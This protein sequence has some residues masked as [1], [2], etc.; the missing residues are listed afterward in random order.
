MQAKIVVALHCKEVKERISGILTS[1]EAELCYAETS[2]ECLQLVAESTPALLILGEHLKDVSA[3][4]LASI[5]RSDQTKL[6]LPMLLLLDEQQDWEN[7]QYAYQESGILD[8][9]SVPIQEGLLRAKTRVYLQ[10][11]TGRRKQQE[12]IEY[13]ERSNRELRAFAH[14]AAHDLKAPL[15][16]I[17]HFSHILAED[18]LSEEER[19]RFLNRVA[20]S[21]THMD[22]MLSQILEYATVGLHDS[23]R[24]LLDLDECLDEV[25]IRLERQIVDSRA[26]IS[27][28]PL[29]RLMGYKSLLLRLLQNLL[30]NAIKYSKKDTAPQIEVDCTVVGRFAQLSIKDYGIGFDMKW[31]DDIFRPFRRLVASTQHNGSGIGMA[32]AKRI[33]EHH[34]GRIRAEGVLDEGSTFYIELPIQTKEASHFLAQVSA[35]SASAVTQPAVKQP[36]ME[37]NDSCREKALLFDFSS[38]A[39]TE[40]AALLAERCELITVTSL[41]DALSQ[42]RAEDFSVVVCALQGASA[43]LL[44]LLQEVYIRQPEAY[45]VLVINGAEE[46]TQQLSQSGWAH[47]CFDQPLDSRELLNAVLFQPCRPALV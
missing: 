45:R 26:Q 3:L 17:K 10:Q 30:A 7:V 21:A 16:A 38:A 25:K 2:R 9:L 19:V 43:G 39:N 14:S 20:D 32:T 41:E 18:P 37:G 8:H 31:H 22:T 46:D 12:Q 4:E 44:A 11:D 35:P 23:H 5:I 47:Q 13:L 34:G 42:L 28:A 36:L 33:V 29:P 1:S 15:R 24:E 40:I 6:Y 27:I